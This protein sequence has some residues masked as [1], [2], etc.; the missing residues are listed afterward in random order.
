MKEFLNIYFFVQMNESAEGKMMNGSVCVEEI[1]IYIKRE[2]LS[3][4]YQ[5]LVNI[6][7]WPPCV[8]TRR[9]GLMTCMSI[10]FSW[11]PMITVLHRR[12]APSPCSPP[13]PFALAT[14]VSSE[15]NTQSAFHLQIRFFFPVKTSRPL[16][17][18]WPSHSSSLPLLREP[19]ESSSGVSMSS[20]FM[21]RSSGVSR[22]S[23]ESSEP[24]LLSSDRLISGAISVR[25]FCRTDSVWSAV[26]AAWWADRKKSHTLRKWNTFI[27]RSCQTSKRSSHTF[28]QLQYQPSIRLFTLYH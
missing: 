28:W 8:T 17:S 15:K 24:S 11:S 3:V 25:R 9:Y 26:R 13:G 20:T 14:G 21:S 7:D 23:S 27:K 19:S 5:M 10:L 1:Y 4:S 22:K 6:V 2:V 18:D 12:P 16:T